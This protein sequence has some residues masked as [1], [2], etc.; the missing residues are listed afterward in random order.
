MNSRPLK[1]PLPLLFEAL[2]RIPLDD[3]T[4]ALAQDLAQVCDNEDRSVSAQTLAQVAQR[5][6]NVSLSPQASGAAAPQISIAALDW[7]RPSVTGWRSKLQAFAIRKKRCVWGMWGGA[8][9]GLVSIGVF[10]A[11]MSQTHSMIMAGRPVEEVLSPWIFVAFVTGLIVSLG[12]MIV[13]AAV[14]EDTTRAK[15]EFEVAVPDLEEVKQWQTVPEIREYLRA[16]LTPDYP[17]L[18]GDRW[19]FNAMVE[20][21]SRRQATDV[22]SQWVNPLPEG[23]LS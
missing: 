22:L 11:Y 19:K 3:A 4:R 14:N 1:T 8:M 15:S 16:H 21:M 13:G 7:G 6:V 2:D 18:Q 9:G 5:Q 12:G 10:G 23:A 20:E 17:L